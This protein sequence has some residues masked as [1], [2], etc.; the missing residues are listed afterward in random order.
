MMMIYRNAE[1][2]RPEYSRHRGAFMTT[3]KRGPR[4]FYC[5]KKHWLDQCDTAV[6]R[7]ERKE[8]IR[9]KALGLNV[10]GTISGKSA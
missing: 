7:K 1:K 2:K 10:E 8:I 3:E 9:R 5:P 6:D 4:C